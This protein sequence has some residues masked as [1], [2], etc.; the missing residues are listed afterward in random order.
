MHSLNKIEKFYP[1]MVKVHYLD[2]RHIVDAKLLSSFY[3]QQNGTLPR[4]ANLTY[5]KSINVEK[6][7]QETSSDVNIF[8]CRFG[9]FDCKGIDTITSIYNQRL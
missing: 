3:G 6:F 7:L 1:K 9:K 2:K 4:G 5:L 8:G